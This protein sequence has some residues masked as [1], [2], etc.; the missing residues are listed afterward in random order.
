VTATRIEFH[1][2]AR[3]FRFSHPVS[4]HGH[5]AL[6]SN[7]HGLNILLIQSGIGPNKARI[8]AQQLLDVASWDVMISTGFA[9]A[10]DTCPIGSVLIGKE[11]FWKPSTTSH[12]S[13][14]P[15]RIV[16]HP[17]WVQSALSLSWMGPEPLRTG[18]FV[19][20]DRVL[21]HSVDKLKLQASTG[22]AGV[23]MESAA[24]GEV[25][26]G[27]GLSFLIVRAISD[28]VNEDL[29]VDFNLFLTPSG[30]FSGVMHI[31]TTPRSWKGFLDLYRHSKQASLQLTRFFEEFFSAVST[32][33]TSPTPL[34]IKS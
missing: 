24:I 26:Q 7:D 17:D 14:T 13:L 31:L 21:T 19:S 12:V 1:A 3:A 15:Q 32:T 16:C 33:P 11:V 18:R 9:G 27:H 22:A 10:L 29:P 8:V 4:H 6:A 30:W 23:D 28:G 34:T 20:V 2:V 25:A 5:R